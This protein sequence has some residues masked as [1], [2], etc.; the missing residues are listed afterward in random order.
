M[1]GMSPAGSPHANHQSIQEHN[2]DTNSRIMI[3]ETE[4]KSELLLVSKILKL[5]GLD[6]NMILQISFK[7]D[8]V[9]VLLKK[10]SDDYDN[11]NNVDNN[12]DLMEVL[13][14]AKLLR[15][16]YKTSDQPP[17]NGLNDTNDDQIDIKQN[18][19]NLLIESIQLQLLLMLGQNAFDAFI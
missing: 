8:E 18:D 6:Y 12:Y 15:P 2:K 9:E 13:F 5:E 14:K 10:L 16:K 17:L 4:I 19:Q 3:I 1:E 11:D 7:K